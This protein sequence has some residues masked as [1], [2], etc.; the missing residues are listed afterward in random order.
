MILTAAALV[1]AGGLVLGIPKSLWRSSG[2]AGI[3]G[4]VKFLTHI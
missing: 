1:A 4:S 3:V 2:T